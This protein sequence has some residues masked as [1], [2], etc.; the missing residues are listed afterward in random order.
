MTPPDDDSA[1]RPTVTASIGGTANILYAINDQ[2]LGR[3]P[4][5]E[6]ASHPSLI[7]DVQLQHAGLYKVLSFYYRL[8]VR[9]KVYKGLIDSAGIEIV[10]SC[11][12]KEDLNLFSNQN[13][14]W[15]N[16]S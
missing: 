15:L 10:F 7:S 4:K 14:Y 6:W 12:N 13:G 1:I 5:N 9:G 11:I 16:Y 2:A 8:I 3:L